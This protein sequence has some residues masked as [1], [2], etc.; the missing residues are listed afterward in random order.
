MTHKRHHSRPPT[1]PHRFPWGPLG[2][3]IATATV[4]GLIAWQNLLI[5]STAPKNAQST[6]ATL[7]LTAA[8]S[9]AGPGKESGQRLQGS[10]GQA[11]QDT[12]SDSLQPSHLDQTQFEPT[13]TDLFNQVEHGSLNLTIDPGTPNET[14]VTVE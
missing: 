9:E 6:P 1:Q 4:V 5:N 3:G 12:Q 10:G 11:N 8:E 14:P 7:P 13:G 2:A